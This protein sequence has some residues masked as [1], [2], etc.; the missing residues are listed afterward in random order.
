[1]VTTIE[2][3]VMLLQLLDLQ[4]PNMVPHEFESGPNKIGSDALT[5]EQPVAHV[6]QQADERGGSLLR[7]SC[8]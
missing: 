5:F 6:R 8:G 3:V 4:H 7:F 2:G 1:M